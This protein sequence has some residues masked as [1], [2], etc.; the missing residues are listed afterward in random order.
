MEVSILA[1]TITN[2]QLLLSQGPLSSLWANK[3]LTNSVAIN[4]GQIYM[5]LNDSDKR[6]MLFIDKG[7][8]RYV[9]TADVHWNDLRG[10]PTNF[11]YQTDISNLQTALTNGLTVKVS[12][13]GD[14]MTGPLSIAHN[15]DTTSP[16]VTM[17]YNNTTQ[18]LDFTFT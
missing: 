14:T 17:D 9:F 13:S 12:L 16:K 2:L 18:S 1:N 4:N 15:N 7:G 8:E 5:G 10:V 3:A 6:A 11:A